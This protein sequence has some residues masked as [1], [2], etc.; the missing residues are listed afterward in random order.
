MRFLLT[1]LMLSGASM[2]ALAAAPP[3]PNPSLVNKL[4]DKLGDDDEDVRK[5]A[6]KKL[7]EL[8]EDVVPLPRKA[9]KAHSD[10]DVRLR[11]MIVVSAI[12]KDL[13]GEASR[14]VGSADG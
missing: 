5:V 12:E 4:I 7:K 3:R 9:S 2:L 8:G 1:V 14:I 11:V 6:S 13:Y 10:V